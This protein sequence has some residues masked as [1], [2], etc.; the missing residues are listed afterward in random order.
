MIAVGLDL[1]WNWGDESRLPLRRVHANRSNEIR[2]Q[3]ETPNRN[4]VRVFFGLFVRNIRPRI[5]MKD[6]PTRQDRTWRVV[7]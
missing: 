4:V 5:V 1:S 3:F 7:A 2:P 6:Q